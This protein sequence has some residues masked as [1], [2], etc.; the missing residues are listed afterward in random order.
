MDGGVGGEAAEVADAG[1]RWAMRGRACGLRRLS[2]GRRAKSKLHLLA[3]YTAQPQP[4]LSVSLSQVCFSPGHRRGLHGA[5]AAT[6]ALGFNL[7]STASPD[8]EAAILSMIRQKD[9]LCIAP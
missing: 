6:G 7:S 8:F 2:P 3:N 1:G 9:W 5:V 4:L